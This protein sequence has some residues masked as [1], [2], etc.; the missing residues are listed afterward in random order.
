MGFRS[1]FGYSWL[2][3]LIGFV[4]YLC[5]IN[6]FYFI[7]L[8][9]LYFLCLLLSIKRSLFFI[10]HSNPLLFVYN[11]AY[12]NKEDH[13]NFKRS[14]IPSCANYSNRYNTFLR[15]D[16]AQLVEHHLAKVGVAGSNPV[17]RSID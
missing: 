1:L 7:R 8:I 5:F 13:T 16:V 12:C 15:A 17:V 6:F 14:K 4:G 11:G 3:G 10:G 9:R 2:I